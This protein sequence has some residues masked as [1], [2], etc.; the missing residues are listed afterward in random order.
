[1]TN[2]ELANLAKVVVGGTIFWTGVFRIGAPYVSSLDLSHVIGWELVFWIL[3]LI[4]GAIV[5]NQGYRVLNRPAPKTYDSGLLSKVFFVAGIFLTTTVSVAIVAL[6]LF[7]PFYAHALKGLLFLTCVA[8]ILIGLLLIQI[9]SLILIRSRGG[10]RSFLL[11]NEADELLHNDKRPPV[12]Y[13]RPF[14]EELK[15][16]NIAEYLKSDENVM[17]YNFASETI[18]NPIEFAKH[19][20]RMGR[21]GRKRGWDE[22]FLLAFVFSN[23]SPP[24]G[25]NPKTPSCP[26]IR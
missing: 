26:L 4:G 14:E 8:L 3:L 11:I 20:W 5:Y 6:L 16:L 12:V 15:R 25:Q 1:M 7:Y 2:V 18:L 24:L 10:P 13:L 21:S 23:C 19:H 17:V 22:Q 9:S